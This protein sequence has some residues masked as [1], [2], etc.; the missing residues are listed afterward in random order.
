MAHEAQPDNEIIFQRNPGATL[1]GEF[2]QGLGCVTVVDE[3]GGHG[4]N[5][6]WLLSQHRPSLKSGICTSSDIAP[7]TPISLMNFCSSGTRR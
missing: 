5:W 4:R 1:L 7:S 2:G 3:E 6:M